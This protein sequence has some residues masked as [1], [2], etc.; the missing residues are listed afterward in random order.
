VDEVRSHRRLFGRIKQGKSI[1]VSLVRDLDKPRAILRADKADASAKISRRPSLLEGR[2][3]F[4]EHCA[5]L[6]ANRLDSGDD[7]DSDQGGD[8]RILDRRDA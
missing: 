7:E 5:H 6:G 4:V 8:Q 3:D 2:A 1:C